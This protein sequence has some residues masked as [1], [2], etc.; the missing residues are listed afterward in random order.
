VLEQVLLTLPQFIIT[1][2]KPTS[3]CTNAAFWRGIF[4]AAPRFQRGWR[5]GQNPSRRERRQNAQLFESTFLTS[6][7][8]LVPLQFV[9][10]S[11]CG[12]NF[13]A[14]QSATTP[15]NLRTGRSLKKTDYVML[16]SDCCSRQCDQTPM[17]CL[18]SDEL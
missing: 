15:E 10:V 13:P 8:W 16:S 3:L 9:I 7:S 14:G 4:E 6:C 11:P 18:C 12:L 2:L 17:A 1:R 5:R